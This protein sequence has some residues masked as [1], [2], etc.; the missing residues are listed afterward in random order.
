MIGRERQRVRSKKSEREGEKKERKRGRQET[1]KEEKRINR[2]Q[3][4][5]SVVKAL[6]ETVA[7]RSLFQ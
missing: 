6:R 7:R 2:A 1:Q 5:S 3:I 4:I